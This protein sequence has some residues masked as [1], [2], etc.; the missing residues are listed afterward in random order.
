MRALFPSAD[1]PVQGFDEEDSLVFRV[2]E[3]I[4]RDVRLL[5]VAPVA[6]KVRLRRLLA[7]G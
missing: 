7:L 5:P 6:S 4:S 2:A 3:E 1:G